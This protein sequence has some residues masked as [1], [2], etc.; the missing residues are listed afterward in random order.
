M[1]ASFTVVVVVSQ[2]S[3]AWSHLVVYFSIFWKRYSVC[4]G[5]VFL[6]TLAQRAAPTSPIHGTTE[7]HV[8]LRPVFGKSGS[9]RLN[10]LYWGVCLPQQYILAC[11]VFLSFPKLLTPRLFVSVCPMTG[12]MLSGIAEFTTDVV[13]FLLFCCFSRKR[14]RSFA[15]F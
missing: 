11:F 4:S 5:R 9:V 15:T 3:I 7:S 14:T 2:R 13:L 10:S 1:P 6:E 8:K 12:P